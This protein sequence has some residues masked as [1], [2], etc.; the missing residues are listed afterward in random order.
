MQKLIRLAATAGI[1]A[2]AY[3]VANL[4]H[5]PP[6][7]FLFPCVLS[8]VHMLLWDVLK[9]EALENGFFRFLKCIIFF[10]AAVVLTM[11]AF[12]QS[13]A[14]MTPALF[15]LDA[16]V[17]DI[18]MQ[19][20]CGAIAMM[21]FAFVFSLG[22]V[23]SFPNRWVGLAV[24]PI[25]IVAGLLY[26]FLPSFFGMIGV[27]VGKFFAWVVL[28]LPIIV[29]FAYIKENGL[30]YND[31]GYDDAFAGLGLKKRGGYSGGG[32]MTAPISEPS[33]PAPTW[34]DWQYIAKCYSGQ[35][36]LSYGAVYVDVQYSNDERSVEFY[37]DAQYE[38]N[39]ITE[40]YQV[41]N[42][43]DE[44]RSILADVQQSVFSDAQDAANG[45]VR[46]SVRVRNVRAR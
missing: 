25:S 36:S 31:L 6:H 21:C 27:G 4:L 26:G 14:L 45:H 12:N 34:R 44:V 7:F 19:T 11:K 35:Q 38:I 46:V 42:S 8:F 17:S 29:L 30:L 15:A 39:G 1:G 20:V 37:I 10:V 3:F 5:C 18:Q 40:Q 2:L 28:A 24:A 32:T 33:G 16:T 23:Q 43:A 9:I 22:C 41:D 13:L